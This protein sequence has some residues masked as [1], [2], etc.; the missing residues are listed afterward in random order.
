M[1]LIDTD[2]LIEYLRGS[3]GAVTWLATLEEATF[4]IP[5]VVAMELVLGCRNSI[6]LGQIKRFL[7][8][9][10]VVWPDAADFAR[11]YEILLSFRL[12]SGLGIPDCLIAAM[13]VD[14]G[15]C[16]YTF[17]LKHFRVVPGLIVQQPY[18][19]Q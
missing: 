7:A 15:A 12:S 16:L 10:P 4:A 6:E 2:V 19:R 11:A 8:A 18:L 9:Y 3:A 13:A 1:I 17:N 5:G 14:R